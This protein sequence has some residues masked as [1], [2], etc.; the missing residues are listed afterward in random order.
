MPTRFG[1]RRKF[2]APFRFY[3][4]ENEYVGI[5]ITFITK[6]TLVTTPEQFRQLPLP[7]LTYRDT[8]N[9]AS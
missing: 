1:R 3:G 5:Q 4:A 6:L 2:S 9:Q 7:Q 8:L